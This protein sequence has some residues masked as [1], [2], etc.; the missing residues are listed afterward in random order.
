MNT[1]SVELITG[2]SI[3]IITPAVVEL[4]KQLGLPVRFAGLTAILCAICLLIAGGIANGSDISLARIAT[5]CLSGLVYGL[6]AA[7]LYSQTR[8]RQG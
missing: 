1:D 8:L 2:V 5:W 3:T 6:A 4:A 7:G